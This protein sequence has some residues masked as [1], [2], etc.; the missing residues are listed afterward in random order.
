M[1]M[2]YH[3]GKR[4]SVLISF[5]CLPTVAETCRHLHQPGPRTTPQCALRLRHR[6]ADESADQ[7]PGPADATVNTAAPADATSVIT[8]A[9]NRGAIGHRA[10]AAS[11]ITSPASAYTAPTQ[12]PSWSS[13]AWPW[14]SFCDLDWLSGL[15]FGLLWP[16]WG[17]FFFFKLFIVGL[18]FLS[19][20]NLAKL[21]HLMMAAQRRQ[22]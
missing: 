5:I 18:F 7:Q 12:H 2:Y 10:S 11:F 20:F 22:W 17:F 15:I 4:V 3:G 1:D 14:H 16:L 6:A 8:I 19:F 21:M 9:G 13:P